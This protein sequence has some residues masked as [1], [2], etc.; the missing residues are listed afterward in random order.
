M[1]PST[2]HQAGRARN[3]HCPMCPSRFFSQ[4]DLRGHIRTH[5]KERPLKCKQCKYSTFKPEDLA[6]HERTVHEKTVKFHCQHPDCNFVTVHKDSLQT[7]RQT[8]DLN[9]VIDRPVPCTYPTCNYR[10]H[11]VSTL[12]EHVHVRHDPSRTKKFA[13]PKCTKKFYNN[14]VLH[15]HINVVHAGDTISDADL[16]AVAPLKKQL[17]KN[18]FQCELCDYRAGHREHLNAHKLTIH[19]DV[20]KFKCD[21]P[22]CSYKTNYP[23]LF[24]QHL[25][26]H[27][28]DPQKK[29]PAVCR[30]PGCDYRRR[31]RVQLKSHEEVHEDSEIRLNCD[32]C[33]DKWYPDQNSLLFHSWMCHDGKSYECS[34]CDYVVH[35]LRHLA[36]HV[37]KSHKDRLI[38]YPGSSKSMQA[39]N[40]KEIP[41]VLLRRLCVEIT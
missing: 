19:S 2:K 39:C 36:V 18:Y 38:D 14:H 29:Y 23:R 40:D 22:G 20:R 13:C 16:S 4:K 11:S 6:R 8:H 37:N 1:H 30:F 32:L 9:R 24:K 41:V 33:P 35:E 5:V 21:S 15:K 27:E 25:L 12:R 26:I 3:F 10:A 31:S 34:Y 28:K 17:L 7:H